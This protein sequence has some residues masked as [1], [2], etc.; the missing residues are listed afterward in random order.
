[1]R[2]KRRLFLAHA[3][4]VLFFFGML[5]FGQEDLAREEAELF[6]KYKS[7]NKNYEKGKMHFAREDYK[8]AKKEFE[9]I[10]KNLPNHAD[11]IF[12][13]SQ[14][15]YKEGNLE[16][17]LSYVQNAKAN[18]E[19]TAKMKIE[20]TNKIIKTNMQLLEEALRLLQ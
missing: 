8:K 7:L 2:N 5:S 12:F 14:I 20:M 10:L 3:M 17:A 19:F 9:K 4:I 13:L 15:F 6:K 18:Y 16:D 1:M 11:A